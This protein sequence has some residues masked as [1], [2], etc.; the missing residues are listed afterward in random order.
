MTQVRAVNVIRMRNHVRC[1]VRKTASDENTELNRPSS[2]ITRSL[3]HRVYVDCRKSR[4]L[5]LDHLQQVLSPLWRNCCLRIAPSPSLAII[6]P[7]QLALAHSELSK[8]AGASTLRRLRYMEDFLCVGLR[9]A[10]ETECVM[11][12][13]TLMV[14][15]GQALTCSTWKIIL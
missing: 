11:R 2:Q 1:S 14:L 13:L 6:L 4:R 10:S 7:T 8:Y 9:T 3:C 15:P 12:R 5:L